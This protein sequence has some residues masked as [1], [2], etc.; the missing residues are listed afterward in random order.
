M[1]TTWRSA[2]RLVVLLRLPIS[3]LPLPAPLRNFTVRVVGTNIS[4]TTNQEG[5]FSLLDVPAGAATIEVDSVTSGAAWAF[6]K[7]YTRQVIVTAAR[8]NLLAE[9]F[10]FPDSGI[11]ETVSRQGFAVTGIVLDADRELTISRPKYPRHS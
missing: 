1:R 8:D 6:P 11:S 5:V 7:K 9:F 3:T 4:A 2:L 10:W